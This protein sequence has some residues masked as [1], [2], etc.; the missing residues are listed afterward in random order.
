MKKSVSLFMSAL[1]AAS[2]FAGCS[3]AAKPE[4][5]ST[6]NTSTTQNASA[7]LVLGE[8]SDQAKKVILTNKTGKT[9]I[10]VSLQPSGD[11]QDPV[12]LLKNERTWM[13]SRQA[14]L[15][16]AN[17]DQAV[18]NLE[19]VIR[20][21][22]GQDEQEYRL[23]NF[24]VHIIAQKADLILNGDILEVTWDEG[25]QTQASTS[26]STQPAE[27]TTNTDSAGSDTEEQDPSIQ[28]SEQEPI[29]I[30]P[31][32]VEPDYVEPDYVEPDVDNG[33]DAVEPDVE[34]DPD[35]PVEGDGE[36]EQGTPDDAYQEGME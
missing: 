1:M 7:R 16:I 19:L 23:E 24:P 22:D 21:K 28:D 11:Q 13:D 12:N 33:T 5:T 2:V 29:Y 17:K 14:D 8:E 25:G 34:I 18:D 6:S 35:L 27:T 9:I 10:S 36:Y 3:S 4:Q 30:E 32:Y 20:T 26:Q 15:Y 31:V